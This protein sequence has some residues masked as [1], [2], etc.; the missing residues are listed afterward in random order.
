LKYPTVEMVLA[1]GTDSDHFEYYFDRMSP[2]WPMREI[3]IGDQSIAI[4]PGATTSGLKNPVDRDIMDA[5][6]VLES[7]FAPL[8][9]NDN[10]DKNWTKEFKPKF[11]KAVRTGKL[12]EMPMDKVVKTLRVAD[13]GRK[14]SEKYLDNPIIVATYPGA[15]YLE[16]LDGS[17]RLIQ[18]Y[19]AGLKDVPVLLINLPWW[20]DDFDAVDADTIED[21]LP[22]K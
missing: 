22:L 16:V 10:Y 11:L 18:R 13:Y 1:L 4:P 17:H 2:S 7:W 19:K 12:M 14:I 5:W 20:K 8:D 9:D 21:L 6:A 3:N 15:H